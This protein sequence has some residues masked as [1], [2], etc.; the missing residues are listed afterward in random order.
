MIGKSAMYPSSMGRFKS[1]EFFALLMMDRSRS[2]ASTKRRGGRGSP[3]LTH[4]LQWKTFPGTPF[5]NTSDVVVAKISLIQFV[6]LSGNPLCRKI[7]RITWSSILS[8]AFPKSSFKI[9]ISF[10]LTCDRCEDIQ[11]TKQDNLKLICF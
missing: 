8:K 10:F 4:L 6:H 9:T 2:A 3:C 5:N 11:M 1:P 7:C